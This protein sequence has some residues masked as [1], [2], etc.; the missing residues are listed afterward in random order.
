MDA[1]IASTSGSFDDSLSAYT[2]SPCVSQRL[3]SVLCSLSI[4]SSAPIAVDGADTAT[5]GHTVEW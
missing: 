5:R 3:T 4:C 2:V 1:G